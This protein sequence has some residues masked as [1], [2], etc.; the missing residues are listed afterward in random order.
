MSDRERAA[1]TLSGV[2][3]DFD[4]KPANKV[5]VTKRKYDLEILFADVDFS[6]ESPYNGRVVK[7][8]SVDYETADQMKD[9]LLS[10]L[11]ERHKELAARF[12]EEEAAQEDAARA[13]S[14][15]HGTGD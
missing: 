11:T 9:Q 15:V 1:Y 7:S 14:M 2:N 12:E 4:P 3:G 6:G 10:A 13:S 5:F 8:V